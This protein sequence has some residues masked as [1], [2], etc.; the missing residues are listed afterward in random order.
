MSKTTRG[1][2]KAAKDASLDVLR[3]RHAGCRPKGRYYLIVCEGT[4]T[5]PNYFNRMRTHLSGGEGSKVVVVGAQDNTLRLVDR[6]REEIAAR[7][8]SDNPP[9]YHVWL[10]F[11]KDSFPN[12]HFDNTIALT[13]IEDGK[14][15][16]EGDVLNPHWHAAWSNE[17]FELW[18]LFHFQDNVGGGITRDRY[19]KMLS[20]HLGFSYRKNAEDMFDI[21]LP[22]MLAAIE[23]AERAFLRWSADV[24]CHRRNPATAVYELV[25][26]LMLYI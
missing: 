9:F 19:E 22:R 15:G 11:D 12:D 13:R 1:L 26:N 24:P 10:V 25:K 6:A 2:I 8:K 20:E 5:E 17:A 14:F 23:R 4:K 7:N 3:H 18:Y 16:M 21:L